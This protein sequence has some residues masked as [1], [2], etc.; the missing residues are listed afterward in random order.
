MSSNLYT[1]LQA[2]FAEHRADA[3]LI[4][5]D[6][7]IVT[8]GELDDLSARFATCLK[9]KGVKEGD[10]ITVQ[11][12]KSAGNV[13]LYLAVLR[14]GA[15]YQALNIGYTLQEV[16][17]FVRDA[18]PTLFVCRP[19]DLP[20][21]EGVLNVTVLEMGT[22][23]TSGLW[24]EA[25]LCSPLHD[26]CQRT[27]DDLA[28]ILYTSGTTGQ[29]KGAMLSHKNL[30]SNAEVL[31]DLWGFTDRDV[32]IHALPIFH[33]HGLFVAL[34]CAMMVGAPMYFEPAFN[35]ARVRTLLPN[36]TVLMGV[37]TFYTR[38][39]TE[40]GFGPQDCVNMR[41]FISGSAPMTAE[42]HEAFEAA[43]GHRVLER[44]GMTETG[45]LTS[46]PLDGD[47]MAGT[48]G[49]ALPGTDV[50]VVG[51]TGAVEVHGPNV[52]SGYWR[53]PEKTKEEFTEDGFFKTGD[54]G[55]MDTEGRLT[56]AGRAKDLIISGGYNIYPKEIE[57][58]LDK[59]PGILESAVIA[60]PHPDLGEGVV[61]ILVAE[62]SEVEN[63]VLQNA[64]G[65]SLARFKHP[66]RFFW[67]D[68][69]PR[70]TM[71][72]VQKKALRE[73]YANA[74]LSKS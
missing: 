28:A 61:A 23:N 73:T 38:L 35:S 46:N 8:Y 52:F 17:F 56:L 2:G 5:P 14:I 45:M 71:G 60:A 27:P 67:V 66:R 24:A 20:R 34:H 25:V 32:L 41:L 47:R 13:A 15:V 4:L 7:T 29:P 22:E 10:R 55:H 49:F 26:I 19:E 68:E 48:V 59:I 57:T 54:V 39:M 6:E 53:L 64:L 65:E 43:S 11:I 37:P 42:V 36:S 3:A 74:Y 69:L 72:K 30:Q 70:N 50:R 18:E 9:A 21:Y 62:E 63:T 58:V 33:V 31:V 40:E 44:Y 16:E 1:A 12:D 51:E